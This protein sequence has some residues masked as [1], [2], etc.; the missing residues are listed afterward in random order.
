MSRLFTFVEVASDLSNRGRHY[1][2]SLRRLVEAIQTYLRQQ[3]GVGTVRTCRATAVASRRLSNR[4]SDDQISS[5]ASKYGEGVSSV[6]LA[7]QYGVSKTSIVALLRQQ[8]IPIRDKRLTPE[9]Q[10][11]AISLYIEGNSLATIGKR[12]N[13][14]PNSVRKLLMREG[15]SRRN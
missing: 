6:E 3:I 13:A 15:V 14:S 10:Q 1:E 11:L 5:I 12:I 2:S 8:H 7:A 9:I 4:L